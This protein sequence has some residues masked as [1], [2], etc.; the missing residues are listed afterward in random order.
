MQQAIFD[1]FVGVQCV[2]CRS[3]K[4]RHKTNDSPL[5]VCQDCLKIFA[6]NNLPRCGECHLP[7]YRE[8]IVKIIENNSKCPQCQHSIILYDDLKSW[9]LETQ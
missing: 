4:V 7:F 5:V 9:A 2:N 8:N 1:D 6:A 3:W